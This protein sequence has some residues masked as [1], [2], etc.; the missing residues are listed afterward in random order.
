MLDA[1]NRTVYASILKDD[2][3][4]FDSALHDFEMIVLEDGHSAD[5]SVTTYYFYEELGA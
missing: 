2:T 4:G 1:S 3:A 5:E